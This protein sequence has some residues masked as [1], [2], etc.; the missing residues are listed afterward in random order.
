[1]GWRKWIAGWRR[2]SPAPKPVALPRSSP[3]EGGDT[4]FLKGI[5]A[6]EEGD[7]DTAILCFER[8]IAA[9]YDDAEAHHKLGLAY[10]RQ[11]RIEQAADSFAMAVHFRPDFVDAHFNLALAAQR[12]GDFARART[13]LKRVIALRPEHAE[14]YNALGAIELECGDSVEAVACFE[15]AVNLAPAYAAAHNNLGYVLFRDLG[16]Y[17]RGAQHIQTALDLNPADSNAWCNQTIV[18]SHQ[19]RLDEL[20]SVCDQLLAAK[21]QLHEARLNRALAQLKRG[22]YEAAWPDYEARKQVRSNYIPRPYTY[23]EWGGEPL[24]GKRMLIYAEQGLGDEIMFASCL[25]DVLR[26]AESC[27]IECSARLAP[28][29]Q[30]SF[31]SAQ[32]HAGSQADN[33]TA[34]LRQYEPIDVQAAIGSLPQFLRHHV[35]DFPQHRGYLRADASRAAYWRAALDALGPGIKIGISWRGGMPSTRRDLRSMKLVE[36]LPL[37][38]CPD[39]H[40]VSL[41]YGDV[42]REIESFKAEHLLSLHHWE[43]AHRDYDETAG[44]IDA[45]DLVISVQTAV[46]HLGGALGKQ[47]WVMVP[48]VPEWRYLQQGSSMP[49]YPSV[50]LFR[51]EREGEW[52]PVVEALAEELRRAAS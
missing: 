18:L 35:A 44:L 50:R 7:L 33:D 27:V 47:T 37:L 2:P 10:F 30:R 3:E 49:W 45:L 31:P 15:R 12:L 43:Q 38:Q 11:G 17:R 36:W 39:S 9:R 4:L 16:H 32:V 26:K 5:E 51:Q 41:Q 13:D 52:Q 42:A 21:P 8:V 24:T 22:R 48:A 46:V 25:P 23:P 6:D 20:I 14:A 29:F 40:F 19:G 1:M 34:W 28:L